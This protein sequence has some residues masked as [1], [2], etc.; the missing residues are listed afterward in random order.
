M[1]KEHMEIL[2]KTLRD[3]LVELQN[4]E[5]AEAKNQE[6]VNPTPEEEIEIAKKDK[7]HKHVVTECG[8]DVEFILFTNKH[9]GGNEFSVSA[10][11]GTISEFVRGLVDCEDKEIRDASRRGV[12]QSVLRSL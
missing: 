11:N 3:K 6:K 9:G 4:Q 8:D 10:C 5:K 1:R 7:L 2:A 12:T